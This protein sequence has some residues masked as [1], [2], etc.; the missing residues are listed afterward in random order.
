[1][2]PAIITFVKKLYIENSCNHMRVRKIKLHIWKRINLAKY[3]MEYIDKLLEFIKSH[4]VWCSKQYKIQ[5]HFYK[6][7]CR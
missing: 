6:N 4:E 1:M 2:I 3:L 7:K 5:V